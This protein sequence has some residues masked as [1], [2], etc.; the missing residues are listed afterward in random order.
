MSTRKS[1]RVDEERKRW[2]LRDIKMKENKD[3]NDDENEGASQTVV[4]RGEK[5]PTAT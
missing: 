1:R 2:N 4:R 5:A 3:E